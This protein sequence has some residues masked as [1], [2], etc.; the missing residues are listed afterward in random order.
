MLINTFT[1]PP[2]SSY[3]AMDTETHTYV[4]GVI[5]DK[6]EIERMMNELDE[7]GNRKYPVSWWRVH[8]RVE[9][10]AF[11]IYSPEGVA[12]LETFDEYTRFCAQYRIKH[13]WWYNA[14][15][16][17]AALDSAKFSAGWEYTTEKS[18]SANTFTELASPFGARYSMTENHQCDTV[19]TFEQRAT[20]TVQSTRHY[21]IRNLLKG[22]LAGLLES[23]DVRDS[24]G[25]P[26]RKRSMNY[27]KA[28]NQSLTIDDILY[29]ID[30]ARGLWWLIQTFGRKL[31]DDYEIDILH[32][33][34][35]VLTA[36]GLAKVLL[37]RKM[38]PHVTSDRGARTCYRK[39]HPVSTTMDD[40]YRRGHLLQG[41]LV[42]LNPRAK[43]RHLH[44]D[45][46][47]I[48]RYD[49][50]SHYPA[51]MHD[52]SDIIGRPV[53]LTGRAARE[54]ADEIRVFEIKNLHAILRDGMIPSWLDPIR[55]KTASEVTV[56][57][58]RDG[59]ILM[60]DFEIEE[61][62]KWYH[63]D[64][65]DISRTLF[66]RGRDCP[67]FAEFVDEH[68]NKKAEAKVRKDKV[69]QETEKLILNGVT[70]KFSQNPNHPKQWRERGDDGVVRLMR[71][72][73]EIDV[74]EKSIMNIVQGAFILAL[75]RCKLRQSCR[76]IA[77]GVGKTVAETVIYT[78]TDSIHTSVRYEDTDPYRLGALK[79]ENETPIGD[80]I[81][82]APKTYAEV[83]AD[84]AEM[85]CKGVNTS[86]L[87][88]A[89]NAGE[90]LSEIYRIG[91]TYLSNQAIN[92]QGGKAIL[93]LP[94]AV[95]KQLD[96]EL[97]EDELYF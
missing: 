51:I 65:I 55:H 63:I 94:K 34:P 61:L 17:F 59:Y 9:V 86:V 43:G 11:I 10:W 60:F 67:A 5:L 18:K 79:Q 77:R 52:C 25:T 41:G 48:Y 85:H 54:R 50:N 75:A 26:I 57:D 7:N 38:Y 66:F 64:T 39:A 96:G 30:D 29:M 76:R 46:V 91:R 36:S 69:A 92:V 1:S 88:D 12:I 73:T 14:P 83:D 58:W 62:E 68:Y 33:K 6:S 84:G 93:P 95:C 71:D 44:G 89:Y 72:G 42:M 87:R 40:Y 24:D 53:F 22:G 97:S 23:F 56:Y 37:L 28:G 15:F 80:A 16:D 49:F 90:S 47:N 74:D 78:D 82:V 45:N 19:S 13:A 35:D 31:I 20:R 4:D 32:G 8:T 70:G 81:F 3:V 27:Q 2:K 21:D